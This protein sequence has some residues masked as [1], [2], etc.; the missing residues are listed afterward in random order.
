[1][2]PNIERNIEIYRKVMGGGMTMVDVA[3]EYDL[4]KQ[5]VH[6]IMKQFNRHTKKYAEK[7]RAATRNIVYPRIAEWM[8]DNDFKLVDVEKLLGYEPYKGSAVRR[9]LQGESGGNIMLIKAI[10]VASG[11]TFEEA[12]S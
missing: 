4:T 3:K 1:M 9:F 8:N 6:Q 12:F 7:K 11:L 2:E 5:R 10:L